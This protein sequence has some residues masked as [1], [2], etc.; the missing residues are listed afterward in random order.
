MLLAV[1][2]MDFSANI[3]IDMHI[4]KYIASTNSQD[5]PCILPLSETH[6][7]MTSVQSENKA[8]KSNKVPENSL[9]LNTSGNRVTLGSA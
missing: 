7:G 6:E 2:T 5:L 9:L 3:F 8:F 1:I 4:I